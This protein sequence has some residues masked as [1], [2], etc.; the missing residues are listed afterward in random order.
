V[1]RSLIFI[2]F[3]G[4]DGT[5]KCIVGWSA[6]IHAGNVTAQAQVSTV[7]CVSERRQLSAG[8][9]VGIR[10]EVEPANL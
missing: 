9:E 3:Q 6:G 2:Y 4:R 5:V 8:S 7:D 10:D 1:A